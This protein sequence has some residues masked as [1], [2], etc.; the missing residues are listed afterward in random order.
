VPIQS[1]DRTIEIDL[2]GVSVRAGDF[3]EEELASALE[4]VLSQIAEAI[5]SYAKGRAFDK[6]EKSWIPVT[7]AQ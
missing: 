1:A 2:S 3:S 7:R 6:T 5:S 4:P